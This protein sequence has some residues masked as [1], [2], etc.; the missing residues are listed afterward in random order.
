MKRRDFIKISTA[1]TAGLV[2]PY[3]IPSATQERKMRIGLIG[4]GWYGRVI[5]TA[6]LKA[7]GVEVI[8]ICDVDSDHLASSADEVEKMQGTKPRTFK[9][10]QDLLDMK[11]L[12]AVFIGTIP[13]WHALQFIAACEKKLDIY[14]EKPLA[15]DV[16]E[17]IAMVNAWK[18]AGNIVQLGFQRR[19]SQAFMKAKELIENGTI[20]N[21]H[22]IVA[23]I[24]YNPGP[25]DTKIQPPPPSLDW[26]DWCGPAP[27][28]DY[29]PSIAHRSWRLEKEYG[30]GHLVDWGIH[31]IDIIRKIMGEG[32]PREFYSTG[33][34]FSL[35][36]QITSPDT[37]T[38]HMAFKKAPVIWQHRLWGNGD[39][40]REFNNGIF[41]YGDKGTLFAEDNKVVVFPAGRNAQR[42]DLSIPT[43]MMQ[44]NHV[45]NFL[46]AVRKKDR[47]LISCDPEDAFRS[48]A[49]VQLATIAYNTGTVVKWDDE[50]KEIIG[51]PAATALLK[52]EYRGRYIHPQN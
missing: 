15:Y 52:R 47:S 6:A 44:D 45:I 37:L 26:E 49:T 14:C 3:I 18:K 23:Q 39:V 17:G 2:S 29:R 10:Y 7:G 13:H 32:M 36:D 22:Q 30:N 40:T 33:G 41:F 9:Y 25:Q 31:H 12:E 42:E 46:D 51:N 19:Q 1:G 20:G 16:M 5:T 34:I 4:A 24:H 21:V 43:P 27:K 35:K 28:L 50:K 8:G 38:A 11:G 48:S